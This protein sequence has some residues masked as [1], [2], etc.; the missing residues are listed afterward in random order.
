PVTVNSAI[1]GTAANGTDYSAI[2]TSVVIPAGLSSA[3]ITIT[4]IDDA[5]NEVNET[6]ALTLTAGSYN[7]AASPDNAATVTIADDDPAP[8][9]S[10]NAASSSGLEN[11]TA[12]ALPV[13]L[14]A[15]SGRT[16]TVDYAVTG[17]TAS[18][19]GVDYSL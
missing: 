3:T 18:G 12:V 15:A 6:V 1:S 7:I 4:P 13:S 19:G 9:V 14:S 8:T 5:F 16:V 11:I 10:F 2:G 17:G